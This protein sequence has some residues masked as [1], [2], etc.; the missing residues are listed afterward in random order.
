MNDVHGLVEPA[1]ACAWVPARDCYRRRFN[2][3]GLFSRLDTDCLHVEVFVNRGK[4]VVKEEKKKE[5][6]LKK[7][8]QSRFQLG[9]GVCIDK[10][11]WGHLMQNYTFPL[12]FL[13]VFNDKTC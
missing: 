13:C 2:P 10:K 7:N 4:S 9:H 1:E 3:T 6:N 11:N 12:S 8:P 5:A